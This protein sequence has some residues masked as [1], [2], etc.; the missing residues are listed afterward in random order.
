MRV[1]QLVQLVRLFDGV[2]FRFGQLS[3][4]ARGRSQ[5]FRS[6]FFDFSSRARSMRM[7]GVAHI[8]PKV[9][10]CRL[11]RRRLAM[12]EYKADDVGQQTKR[13]HNDDQPRVADV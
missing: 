1:K 10:P 12:E 2:L 9:S 3:L 11:H 6:A 13:A 8:C 5:A 4:L 7:A